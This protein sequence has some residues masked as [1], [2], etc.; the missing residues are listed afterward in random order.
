MIVLFLRLHSNMPNLTTEVYSPT[1]N[2]T[3]DYDDVP[4]LAMSYFTYQLGKSP[5]HI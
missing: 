3:N 2:A 1:D 4:R 5:S